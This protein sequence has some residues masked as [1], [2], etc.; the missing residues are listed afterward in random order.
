MIPASAT[1]RGMCADRR[2]EKVR[3]T[4]LGRG[5]YAKDRVLR[6]DR[7]ELTEP[8][9]PVDGEVGARAACHLEVAPQDRRSLAGLDFLEEHRLAPS[10]AQHRPSAGGPHVRDPV[11]AFAEH[12]DEI[13]L[14]IEVCDDNH[15][16]WT[17]TLGVRGYGAASTTAAP[18]GVA[19]A[20]EIVRRR[21]GRIAG[22]A[23]PIASSGARCLTAAPP[24]I[25]V[26]L[27]DT[28]SGAA[29]MLSGCESRIGSPNGA[30]DRGCSRGRGAW[31]LVG[32]P[33]IAARIWW[34][35]A[36]AIII[37]VV[38][39]TIYVTAAVRYTHRPHQH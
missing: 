37:F 32:L 13:P 15:V 12:R 16:Q 28:P 25:G 33:V 2:K 19:T 27:A 29:T 21:P 35:V 30:Q 14:A 24:R 17:D 3:D 38:A 1:S 36:A 4:A 10:V 8:C 20:S 34:S 39:V 9:A 22:C 5:A 6:C 26:V 23:G 11:G 31:L 18:L 7:L